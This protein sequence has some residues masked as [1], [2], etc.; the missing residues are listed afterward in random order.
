MSGPVDSRADTVPVVYLVPSPGLLD[1]ALALAHLGV[2]LRVAARLRQLLEVRLRAMAIDL[3]AQFTEEVS[4]NHLA[5]AT[6]A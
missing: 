2:D 3:V 1:V 6:T 4:L 5:G